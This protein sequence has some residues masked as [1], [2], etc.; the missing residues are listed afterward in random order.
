MTGI[1]NKHTKTRKRWTAEHLVMAKAMNFEGKCSKEIGRITGHF[2]GTVNRN[3]R[4]AGIFQGS[5]PRPL[6]PVNGMLKNRVDKIRPWTPEHQTQGLAMAKA[7]ASLFEIMEALKFSETTV[8]RHLRA[9]GIKGLA[10]GRPRIA[11]VK[12][13]P[14]APVHVAPIIPVGRV[15]DLHKR[16]MSVTV[17]AAQLRIP[18]AAVR[19]AIEGAK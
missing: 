10:Y 5:G 18:Y 1:S 19:A 6:N 3:L 11:V 12:V 15:T 16:G 7:G 14:P 9:G 2:P 13:E 8:S 4:A 17:I